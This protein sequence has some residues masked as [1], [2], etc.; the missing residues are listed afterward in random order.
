MPQSA[1][2][3]RWGVAGALAFA[4]A[5]PAKADPCTAIPERGAMPGYLKR[6]AI[7]SGRVNY[8]GDGDSLCV[9]NW[10]WH[11]A[12]IEV[13]LADFYAPELS[14]PGGLSAKRALTQIAFHKRVTCRAEKRSYDRVVSLCELNGRSLGDLMR[15]RGVTEGGRGAVAKRSSVQR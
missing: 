9:A 8:V 3:C 7:F 13:R 6:G 11:S 10:P 2:L 15:A 4:V 1:W 14:E 5:C 12:W